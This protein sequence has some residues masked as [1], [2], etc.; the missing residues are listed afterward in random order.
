MANAEGDQN[1]PAALL[2]LYRG[3]LGEKRPA[4][5]VQKR[6]PYRLPKMQEGGTGVT[7]DQKKQRERFKTAMDLFA[8][9]TAAERERWYE[10]EPVWNS[11]LWY[12]NFFIMSALTGNA[13][14]D[15]GGV[16]VIK[17]IQHVKDSVPTT[18]GKEFTINSVDPTKC[19]VMLNGSARRVPRVIRGSGSVGT[20]GSQLT[21]SGGIDA[22][23][24]TVKL[25]GAASY[26]IVEGNNIPL[27]PIV[28]ALATNT[29]DIDWPLTPVGAADVSYEI[30]E[31][32]EGSVYP[33]I[34]SIAATKVTINWSE[35]P[36]A[37]ADVSIDVI[38]Y[39]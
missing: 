21:H 13:N 35:T 15:Q 30:T 4:G 33:V 34:V 22:D 3:T 39:I 31:H 24:C 20:S 19:V 23:K 26:E 28:T 29:I 37:A 8:G 6:Y 25:D 5:P 14:L 36:D 2:D 18:G 11:F 17:S 32:N 10:N 12:Y 7:D 16:G 27:A 1:I 9:R 38:E